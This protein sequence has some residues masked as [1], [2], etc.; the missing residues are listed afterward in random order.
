MDDLM[1]PQFRIFKFKIDLSSSL[2]NKE[3]MAIYAKMPSGQKAWAEVSPLNGWSK[4]SLLDAEKQLFQLKEEFLSRCNSFEEG[5]D[6]LQH[7]S[8][9]PSVAFGLESLLYSLF[10]PQ[11]CIAR[12]FPVCALLTGNYEQVC[13][14]ISF[15]LQEQYKHAKL[16]IAGL[17][18]HEAHSA[19]AQ[20]RGKVHLRIDVN[21]KWS[22]TESLSFFSHYPLD[23]FDYIEEPVQNPQDLSLFPFPIALDESLR[24]GYIPPRKIQAFIIKPMMTGSFAEIQQLT[25]L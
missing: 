3:G 8:L 11:S 1:A 15:V 6:F 13:K 18:F 23:A 5:I 9:Y 14:Q 10:T 22:L 25:R 24:E 12:S 7:K 2:R 4:E 21:R 17:T 16:K 20:L 19:I